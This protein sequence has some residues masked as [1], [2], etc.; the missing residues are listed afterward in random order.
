MKVLICK[1]SD[2]RYKEVLEVK[3]WNELM[4]ILL[5]RYDAWVIK[6]NYLESTYPGIQ[7]MVIMYD[8]YLE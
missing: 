5:E 1:A 2:W 8:S 3:D 7:W 6:S 4:E